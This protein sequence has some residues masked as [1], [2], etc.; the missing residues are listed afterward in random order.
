MHVPVLAREVV[1]RLCP[2]PGQ[3]VVD[4]TVGYGGHSW[5]LA[6][7][8]APDGRLIG[9]DMDERELGRTRERLT[10]APAAVSLHHANFSQLAEVLGREGV[11]KVDIILADLGVSSMQVD[12]ESRGISYK[13]ANAPLDMRLSAGL[14]GTAA[15]LLAEISQQALADALSELADE[16]D[17][18]KIAQ[19][20]VSQRQVSAIETTG[21][22]SRLVMNAKGLTD[23]TWRE[24]R[25]TRFGELHP[26]AR[27]FQALRILVNDELG[28][29]RSLLATAPAVL[30]S[31]GRI[32]SSVFTA[33]RTGP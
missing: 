24:S 15:Q 13:H 8:V 7:R 2:R 29:L 22:L 30:A 32:G 28:S 23:K 19:W 16:P 31:G 17:A 4:C 12:D 3:V 11:E 6:Q 14:Q 25:Q 10:V 9:L 18:A 21:Q 5:L 1:E 27:T 20:I 33:A 26:A